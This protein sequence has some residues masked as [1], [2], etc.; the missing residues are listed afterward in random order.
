MR[1]LITTILMLA[2][3]TN[4][5]CIK[6]IQTA[7]PSNDFYL[8]D[9]EKKIIT[10][11]ANRGDS[12]AAFRLAM[13]YGF[14]EFRNDQYLDWLNIAAKN[15]HTTAQY[16]LAYELERSHEE[17]KKRQAI[18]WYNKLAQSGDLRSQIALAE[19]YEA[20]KLV[21]KDLY[22]AK[23]LYEKAAFSGSDSA[24]L[25]MVDI[26]LEGI[27]CDK[28]VITAYSWLLLAETKIHPESVTG[29]MIADKKKKMQEQLSS[30]EIDRAEEKFSGLAERI[31]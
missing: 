31:K 10:T 25:K 28:D 8:S 16:N 20:G 9:E 1:I 19:I 2:V 4:L 5:S 14:Y 29:H 11:K 22:Q 27:G 26:Y 7:S 3:I 30:S 18:S 23:G 24:I 6:N 17:E 21:P 15:G 12:E 13:Y